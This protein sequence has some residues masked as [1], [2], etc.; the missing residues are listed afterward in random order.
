MRDFQKLF[1]EW[2]PVYDETVYHDQGEYNEVFEGYEDILD[3]VVRHVPAGAKTVLEFGVGTGN[4]SQRLLHNGYNVIGVEPSAE[5]RKQVLKKRMDIELREGDFLNIPVT[6]TVDAI[7]STYAFHHLTLSEKQQALERMKAVLA[8]DGHI[9][10]ADTAF[11]N[12][13]AK[14]QIIRRVR[15]QN[16]NSLLEDLQTEYYELLQDLKHVFHSA[17]FT[18]QFSALNRFVWLMTANLTGRAHVRD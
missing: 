6:E 14:Q 11:K 10:F 4:L 2:A 18:V 15:A 1:N 7:V 9:V 13:Q 8:P 3:T 17:G 16:K 5:M 12:E